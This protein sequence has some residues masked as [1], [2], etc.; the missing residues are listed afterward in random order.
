MELPILGATGPSGPN[1]GTAAAAIDKLYAVELCTTDGDL[2]IFTMKFDRPTDANGVLD[3]AVLKDFDPKTQAMVNVV[4]I[5][6]AAHLSIPLPGTKIP[7]VM[8]D[9]EGGHVVVWRHVTS[10]RFV[11]EWDQEHGR[12]VMAGDGR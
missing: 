9:V 8:V 12:P 7:P 6:R 4:N 2:H 1:G 5:V 10:F 11:G 3:F